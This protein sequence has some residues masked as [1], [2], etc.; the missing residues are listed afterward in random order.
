MLLIGRN[1]PKYSLFVY[2]NSSVWW[3]DFNFSQNLIIKKYT[4]DKYI[5]WT[6][7]VVP[8][9]YYQNWV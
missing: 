6:F 7:K 5:P 2:S 8:D 4:L 9:V 3:N 1:K